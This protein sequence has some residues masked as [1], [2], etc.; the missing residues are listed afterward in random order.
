MTK[1]EE[2]VWRLKEQPTTESLRELVKDKLLTN[3]EAREIL[4]AT[5]TIEEVKSR[6]KESFEAE[7]KFLRELVE[8]LSKDRTQIVEV[9]REIKTPVY[10][11]SGWYQPYYCWCGNGTTYINT[12]SNSDYATGTT[13]LNCSTTPTGSFSSINTW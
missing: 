13:A 12:M 5:R 7:I 10:I 1:K 9:I 6:D 11:N 2:I 4:F 3:E 8:K